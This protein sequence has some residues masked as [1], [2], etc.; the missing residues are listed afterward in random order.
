MDLALLAQDGLPCFGEHVSL[1]IPVH[2]IVPT[3]SQPHALLN[4]S[5]YLVR[6]I[7]PVH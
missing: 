5:S 7:L 2:R 6:L 4:P 3:F 1:L